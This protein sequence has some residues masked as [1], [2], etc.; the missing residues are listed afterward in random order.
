MS[1]PFE[2][3]LELPVP[4]QSQCLTVPCPRLRTGER[5]A[6]HH[7]SELL[8]CFYCTATTRDPPQNIASKELNKMQQ[9]TLPLFFFL[10][11]PP[12]MCFYFCLE[13]SRNGV[14]FSLAE[15]MLLFDFYTILRYLMKL[16]HAQ[17]KT[18]FITE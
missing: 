1:A 4:E 18:S 17:G 5:L 13:L 15:L 11:P 7:R 9:I 16:P 8:G 14:F 12:P 2:L 6:D 3:H 10:S